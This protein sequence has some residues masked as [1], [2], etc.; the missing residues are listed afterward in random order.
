MGYEKETK[1]G[2][3]AGT[4]LGKGRKLFLFEVP[5]REKPDKV[6][7][8]PPYENLEQLE[9]GKIYTYE[10]ENVPMT[11]GSGKFYHNFTRQN[12]SYGKNASGPYKIQLESEAGAIESYAMSEP[13][14][15]QATAAP[16]PQETDRDQYWRK[17]EDREAAKEPVIVRESCVSSAATSLQMHH[18]P[19]MT[20]EQIAMDVIILAKAYELFCS[21]G[22]ILDVEIWL[23]STCQ[24]E[25]K[26]QSKLGDEDE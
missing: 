13:K 3:F 10:Q 6:S 4:E 22:N 20:R 2:K 21:T 26:E 8:F 23:K 7:A 17:K 19:K 16:K 1:I 25:K 9:V 5:G 11:D 18:T 12:G 14:R 24:T 15:P